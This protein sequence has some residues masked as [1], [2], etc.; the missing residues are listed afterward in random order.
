M[1]YYFSKENPH[2]MDYFWIRI[3]GFIIYFRGP[4]HK[5]PFTERNGYIKAK[6]KVRGYRFFIVKD[7]WN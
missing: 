4:K 2:A 3:F 6:L 5:A 1:T 7:K